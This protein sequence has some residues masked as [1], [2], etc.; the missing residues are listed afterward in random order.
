MNDPSPWAEEDPPWGTGD[1]DETTEEN[2]E[3]AEQEAAEEE[4]QEYQNRYLWKRYA[5]RLKRDGG[6]TR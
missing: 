3:R 2:I 6:L 5:G 4:R 1:I